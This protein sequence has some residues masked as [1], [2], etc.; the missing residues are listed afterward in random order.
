MKGINSASYAPLCQIVIP[1]TGR[2]GCKNLVGGASND[3]G[4]YKKDGKYIPVISQYDSDYY[5]KCWM[6][7]LKGEYLKG[8]VHRNAKKNGY[9]VKETMVDGKFKM[10]LTRWT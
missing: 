6:N 2:A 7:N 5:D 4:F 1:G 10:T 3:I 9:K 8:I